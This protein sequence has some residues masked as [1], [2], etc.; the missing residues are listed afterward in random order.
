MISIRTALIG[1]V[2]GTFILVFFGCGA[3]SAAVTTG[4]QVGVFQVAIVWGL[5]VALAIHAT[6]ALSGAHLNP[7]VTV[8]ATVW[9]GFDKKR[10]LPYI[11]AQMLGGFLGAAAVYALF[12]DALT[13][14]ELKN[15]ITRGAA[16]SEATA[17][18]FGEFF[19]NP[20]GRPLSEAGPIVTFGRALGAEIICTAMLVLIIFALTDSKNSERPQRLVAGYI[21]LTVALLISLIGPL[22]MCCLNPARDLAPRLFSSLAGWGSVPFTANG[23]GWLVV[24]VLGPVIGG[25]IGGAVHRVFLKDRYCATCPTTSG[26][27]LDFE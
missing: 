20:G 18:V 1:E 13:A 27:K 23:W 9:Q 25:L 7:A 22:T 16:G 14:Y 17:M 26:P 11:G 10:A 19:P 21:G 24:Y 3:V 6:A 15:G 8:A 2:I 12:S 5:G 4:A